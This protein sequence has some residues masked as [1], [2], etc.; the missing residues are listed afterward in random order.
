MVVAQWRKGA[1][2]KGVRSVL[3][4]VPGLP[5]SERELLSIPDRGMTMVEIHPRTE[6]Q[7][8]KLMTA[9][10]MMQHNSD[11]GSLL[12]VAMHAAAATVR[13]QCAAKLPPPSKAEKREARCRTAGMCICEEPGIT[14]DRFATRIC[15]ALKQ[16]FHRKSPATRAL[17]MENYIVARLKGNDAGIVVSEIFLHVGYLMQNPYWPTFT[18]MEV[19][20]RIIPERILD[21]R[22]LAVDGSH[23]P[24]SLHVAMSSLTAD[25]HWVLEWWKLWDGN[26][27]LDPAHFVPGEQILSR[28]DTVDI[29]FWPPTRK[30]TKPRGGKGKGRG[31]KGRGRGGMLMLGDVEDA[32]PDSEVRDHLDAELS[33]DE[34]DDSPEAAEVTA[35]KD[36]QLLLDECILL[37]DKIAAAAESSVVS[38]LPPAAPPADD[39]E[40]MPPAVAPAP[41][42]PGPYGFDY[43]DAPELDASSRGQPLQSIA[44]NAPG[45]ISIYKGGKVMGYC[46]NRSHGK[47]CRITRAMFK[48]EDGTI[49]GT[50]RPWGQLHGSY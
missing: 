44:F 8:P 33:H 50:A 9:V 17:L 41:P 12:D 2:M 38:H 1:G 19:R 39:A 40:L 46:G 5:L 47:Y 43:A 15:N 23:G 25:L 36:G 42:P 32:P 30:P 29:S 3:K 7:L 6:E 48:E 10:D 16:K 34:G 37:S 45:R 28:L 11:F 14:V 35:K 49:R 24:Q 4:A 20:E 22:L 21:E 26:L 13:P 27:V 18:P 31:R